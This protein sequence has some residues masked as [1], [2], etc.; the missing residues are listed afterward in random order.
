MAYRKLSDAE[1]IKTWEECGNIR[2][3][4]RRLKVT[5]NAIYKRLKRLN[6]IQVPFSDT[7][8]L[9][10]RTIPEGDTLVIPDLQAP[11]HHPDALAFLCAI[12][13]KYKPV[14]VVCIGDEIDLNFLS[15]FA[16]MPE[17]DQPHSEFAAGQN[18]MRALYAEFPTGVSCTSNHVEGRLTKA[19]T[20]GRVLPAMLRSVEDILDAPIGWSWHS[21]IK[22]GEIIFRHGHKDVQNLKRLIVE[23]IPAQEGRHYSII[24]GHYHQKFGMATPDIMIGGKLYWGAFTGCLINPRHQFFSY[25]RG[26]ERLG[27]LMVR[28]GRVLP[29]PMRLGPDGRWEGTL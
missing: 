28:D 15:D 18:F 1:I 2:E 6:L 17:A 3:T 7:A 8:D 13:D 27:A 9:T 12:R 23:E 10:A 20:R 4:S 22:M 11:A 14:N 5:Y 21:Q 16:R 24:I 29:I 25:S 26:Y 19:R